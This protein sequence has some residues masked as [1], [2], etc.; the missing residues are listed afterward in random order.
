M[1]GGVGDP[2]DEG[3]FENLS[4]ADD[5]NGEEFISDLEGDVLGGD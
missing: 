4:H 3:E 5:I 1:R 2:R